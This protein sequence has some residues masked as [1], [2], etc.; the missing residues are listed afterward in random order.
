MLPPAISTL[1]SAGLKMVRLTTVNSVASECHNSGQWPIGRGV[2]D[3]LD[4]HVPGVGPELRKAFL[5]EANAH[6]A[7]HEPAGG[8]QS[9][10]AEHKCHAVAAGLT[11]NDV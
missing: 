10:A 1:C 9:E 8:E 3:D 5:T 11:A 4:I 7:H 2:T 6:Q